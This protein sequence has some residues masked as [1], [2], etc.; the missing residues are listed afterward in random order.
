MKKISIK[1]FAAVIAIT[2]ISV[3]VL[4]A[5]SSKSANDMAYSVT[6]TASSTAPSAPGSYGYASDAAKEAGQY[7]DSDAS[8]AGNGTA[9][10]PASERKL[11]KTVNLSVQTLNFEQSCTTIDS[12]AAS[13]GGYIE[14]SEIYNNNYYYSGNAYL[15]NRSAH[16]V[17]RIPGEK[18]DYF[19][20]RIGDV[21]T[22]TSKSFSTDD[23]TLSYLDVE[24]RAK[25]LKI[26]QE[27]LLALLEKAETVEEIIALEQRISEVTYELELNETTLRN[28]DNLVSFS[29]VNIRLDE[30][31]RVSHG[32]PATVGERISSGLSDTF[33]AI[34]EGATDFFVWFIVY[35]PM[36]AV[37][38]VI[39]AVFI[40]L[41]IL[42]SRFIRCC[43]RKYA[44]RRKAKAA[45]VA[46]TDT[47]N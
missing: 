22:V 30:V 9:S 24:S 44:A 15:D 45:D 47:N 8:A 5:C 23:V 20:S 1:K 16:Y 40:F 14:S 6:E 41:I 35:L 43:R 36:I 3:L 12:Y 28:Y 31:A 33:Y 25:S 17:I 42:I 21:G 2:L 18:L 29:T 13:L 39:V 26:Q 27:R 4:G 46:N 38:L 10:V 32:E 37:W 7:S 19:L 11:I 34:G